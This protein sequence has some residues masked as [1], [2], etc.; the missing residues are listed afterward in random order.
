VVEERLGAKPILASRFGS[1][2][3]PLR[4]RRGIGGLRGGPRRRRGVGG[5][6]PLPSLFRP[7]TFRS[8]AAAYIDS[9][10]E[11]VIRYGPLALSGRPMITQ[12]WG[13]GVR[14]DSSGPP[15]AITDTWDTWPAFV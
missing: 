3:Y 10:R 6:I 4:R 5:E 1:I 11:V 2:G 9:R 7:R 13:P 14:A 8:E 15:C 12:H